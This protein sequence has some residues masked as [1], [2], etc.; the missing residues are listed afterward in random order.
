MRR[1]PHAMS[2][3]LVL[4][5]AAILYA[6]ARGETEREEVLVFPFYFQFGGSAGN[7]FMSRYSLN[8]L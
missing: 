5:Q 4:Q 2:S 7:V 3:D 6:L 8:S 1:P